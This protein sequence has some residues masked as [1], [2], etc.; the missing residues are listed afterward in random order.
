MFYLYGGKG[1]RAW[2]EPHERYAWVPLDKAGNER[3]VV[4]FADVGEQECS[5]IDRDTLVI[6]GDLREQCEDIK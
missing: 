1:E 5:I 6:P 2:R 3:V 4:E